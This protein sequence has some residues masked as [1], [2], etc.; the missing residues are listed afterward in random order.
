MKTQKTSLSEMLNN[1]ISAH[2]GRVDKMQAQLQENYLYYLPWIGEDLYVETYKLKTYQSILNDL[3]TQ[4]EA[5]VLNY[6]L[7]LFK[8]FCKS[9]YNVREN[10][11]GSLHREV[12]TW[13]FVCTMEL[14]ESLE[15][16]EKR[17]KF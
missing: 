13:K 10:S 6:Y 14:I 16:F 2:Q 11:S 12:S 1:F 3:D 15:K 9:S 17:N 4:T 7:L 5:E 8:S